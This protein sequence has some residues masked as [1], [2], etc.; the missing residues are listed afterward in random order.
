MPGKNGGK[1]DWSNPEEVR[2]YNREYYTA[3]RDELVEY[4]RKY[5]EEHREELNEKHRERTRNKPAGLGKK[6][7]RRTEGFWDLAYSTENYHDELSWGIDKE[8]FRRNVEE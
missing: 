5:R 6:K 7:G 2:A 8:K 3:H 4:Q 1:T